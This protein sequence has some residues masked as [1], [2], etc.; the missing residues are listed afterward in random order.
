M[1]KNNLL[2]VSV[3]VILIFSMT[4]CSK[5]STNENSTTPTTGIANTVKKI[6]ENTYS[7][8]GNSIYTLNFEYVGSVLKS[9][10]SNNS[11]VE[12]EYS[13]DKITNL[14]KYNNNILQTT[15]SLTYS[16]V[17][18]TSILSSNGEK[19]EF[20]YLGNTLN[21][22]TFGN[23]N[24]TTFEPKN[25]VAFTFTNNNVTQMIGTNFYN[26]SSS[27]YKTTSTFDTANNPFKMMNPYLK[28]L[29]DFETID[30][31]S[32]NNEFQSFDY[33][34]TTS[35]SA[36]LSQTYSVIYNSQ[37]YPTNVKKFSGT[38]NGSLISEITIEYN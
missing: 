25:S 35:T 20:T 13:G 34:S 10:T 3:L 32:Q 12:L 19:M 37:N 6:T 8:S 4:S 33:A 26:G 21:S 16:G 30:V 23:M 11:K 28:L 27:S 7:T 17:N 38:V 31:K 29:F 36:T 2:F 9:Y 18:L 15:N 14:K 22:S 1:K 5:N 24:G